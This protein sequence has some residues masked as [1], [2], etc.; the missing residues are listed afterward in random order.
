LLLGFI[1]GAAKECLDLGL[2]RIL[3]DR[4][5]D[6]HVSSKKLI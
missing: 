2:G 1:L 3:G 4:D 5:L 6:H